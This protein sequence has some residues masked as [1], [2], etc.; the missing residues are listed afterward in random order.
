MFRTNYFYKFHTTMRY[1]N[2][3]MWQYLIQQ[4]ITIIQ[5]LEGNNKSGN[6]EYN[7]KLQTEVEINN[8]E[9]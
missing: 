8:K 5:E 6:I 7:V 9:S 4:Q 3:E 2:R 1:K